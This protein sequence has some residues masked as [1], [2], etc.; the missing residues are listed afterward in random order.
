MDK[1]RISVSSLVVTDCAAPHA[2]NLQL[3]TN[4]TI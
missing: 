1:E 3:I 4:P 2:L